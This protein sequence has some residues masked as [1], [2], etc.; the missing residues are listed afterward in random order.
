MSEDPA[1]P[2]REEEERER[3]SLLREINEF[4]ETPLIVLSFIWIGL[5]ILEFT[6]GLT[7]FLPT[8]VLIIWGTFIL[9]FIIGFIIAP[10]KLVYLRNSWLTAIALVIPAFRILRIFP[11][12]RVLRA[13]RFIRSANL[14]RILTSTN[15]GLRAL[16]QSLGRR[17]FGYVVLATVM[18]LFVGAGGI[19]QFESSTA[20]ERGGYEDVVGIDSYGDALWWTAMIITTFGS[21]YWP[22]TAEGRVLTVILAVYSV[23]IFGYVTA[24]I[25]SMFVSSDITAR[26]KES[27]RHR[28]PR[29]GSPT[30][31]RS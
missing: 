31:V 12:L 24:T 8:L 25:A 14:V 28:R 9:D 1:N 23:A 13:A 10:R 30:R 15:R 6:R 11:A 27:R 5:L 16:R 26:E 29:P 18:I 21:E 17:G 7:G 20:L 22:Q 2:Q 3:W 19:L 4:T